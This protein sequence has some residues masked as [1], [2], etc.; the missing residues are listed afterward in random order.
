MARKPIAWLYED[1]DGVCA[2][3]CKTKEQA[4]ILMQAVVDEEV[5]IDK[6]DEDKDFDAPIVL[7]L[8]DIKEG[9]GYVTHRKCDPGIYIGESICWGCGESTNTRPQKV[10]TCDI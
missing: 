4:L 2:Q 6:E 5:N 8:E 1:K 3:Y 9:I 10:Y 7:A